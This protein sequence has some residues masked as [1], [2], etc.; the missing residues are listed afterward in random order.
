MRGFSIVRTRVV[1]MNISPG[2]NP[3]LYFISQCQSNADEFQSDEH[4]PCARGKWCHER[5]KSDENEDYA[6]DV[7]EY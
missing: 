2:I 3:V 1:F 6:G 4:Q 5:Q 7:F